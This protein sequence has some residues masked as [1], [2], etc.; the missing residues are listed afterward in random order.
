LRLRLPHR[1]SAR[2]AAASRHRRCSSPTSCSFAFEGARNPHL[3]R[4]PLL[5]G[6]QLESE[7]GTRERRN[8]PVLKACV[9]DCTKMRG[10]S[11][12]GRQQN[13]TPIRKLSAHVG[14]HDNQR[15]WWQ[16]H[17]ASPFKISLQPSSSSTATNL[18]TREERQVVLSSRR[19]HAGGGGRAGRVFGR[20]P[21]GTRA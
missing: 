1:V 6:P 18:S 21:R 2:Q 20:G 17:V 10:E 13:N 8:F 5:K 16:K 3:S 9:E 12:R 11:E 4:L 15:T 14:P 7:V 19:A